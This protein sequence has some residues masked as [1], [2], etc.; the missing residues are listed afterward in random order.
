MSKR[1]AVMD[2]ELCVGCQSCVFACT[3]RTGSAGQ[4]RSSIAVRSI[5]GMERGFVVIVCRACPDP[6]CQKVCPEDALRTRDG[7]GVT[8]DAAKC[9]G[10]GCRLCQQACPF[11][12]VLW[13]RESG[14]PA[15]CVH[16]GYCAKYCPYHVIET[17]EVEA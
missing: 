7:G 11:G 8:L 14:K 2:S 1:L 5:D 15:I 4:G 6:P 13:D 9:L 12:C 3:R 10:A 17:E 16:C